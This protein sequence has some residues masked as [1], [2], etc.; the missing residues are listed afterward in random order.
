[1]Y[2][3]MCVRS[4]V[5]IPWDLLIDIIQYLLHTL[6]D[7]HIWIPFTN[8]PHLS[9]SVKPSGFTSLILNFD[10]SYIKNIYAR[11]ILNF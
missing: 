2:L 1:M 9:F 5:S 6:T 8:V 7:T 11:S 3:H 10:P 4:C